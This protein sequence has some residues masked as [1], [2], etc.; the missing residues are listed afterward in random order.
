MNSTAK[1]LWWNNEGELLSLGEDSEIY[2]W[3]IG[4][5]RCLRRWKD[6][7]GFGSRLLGGDAS[8]KYLATGSSFGILNIYDGPSMTTSENPKPL[9]SLGNLT[10]TISTIRF[11]ADSQLLAM[12]SNTKKDQMRLIHLPSLTA[13][14]NWPTSGTPLGHVSSIDF[15]PDSQHV[16]IGNNR[17]RVLLYHLR[18]FGDGGVVSV[19]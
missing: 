11:N 12:A 8:G 6:D 7:G 3:D 17:G 4:Q 16:V 9:K 1:S 15:A 14:S 10:T 5:R 13:F 2:V 19:I 18:D